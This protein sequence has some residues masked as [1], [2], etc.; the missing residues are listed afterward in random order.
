MG[1]CRQIQQYSSHHEWV[2]NLFSLL[3]VGL[4]FGTVGLSLQFYAD[5]AVW[6][7]QNLVFHGVLLAGALVLDLV[8]IMACLAIG[9]SRADE[10]DK[11]CFA[12][13]QGRRAG[14]SPFAV[15]SAW[16]Q[17]MENVGKK[18]R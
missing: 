3:A 10:E 14:G 17:H 7:D 5:I 13:F 8:L 4:I 2:G 11:P 16:L 18:H 1:V 6:L 15:F 12:T 9:S